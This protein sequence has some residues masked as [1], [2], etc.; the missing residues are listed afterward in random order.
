M[1]LPHALLATALAL[2]PAAAH[3]DTGRS[4]AQPIAV[5]TVLVDQFQ[6]LD[7][8]PGHTWGWQTSAYSRCVDSA[9]KADPWKLDH[10]TS[11]SLSAERGYLTITATREPNGQWS[12][13]LITT[14]DSCDS[15]GDGTQVR[16]G[17]LILVH[18]QLPEADSGAWPGLWT[19]RDGHNEIDVFEWHADRPD[20]LEFVN[21]V[22]SGDTTYT[23]PAIGAGRWIYVGARFGADNT[24]WYAGATLD[25]I[26]A[27]FSDHTGVGNDF[28]AY[29][30]LNL[31]IGNGT[32]HD[33][34]KTDAPVHLSVDLLVIQRPTSPGAPGA[35]A[36]ILRPEAAT[37]HKSASHLLLSPG[38][39]QRTLAPGRSPGR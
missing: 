23:D 34:P 13:G 32:W 37:T 16:T 21:H 22:K 19:W 18:L 3:A 17:D 12:T 20:T 25:T 5:E 6:N 27:A 29:P 31:S 9:D 1:H 8:G 28:A 35:E 30:I 38:P 39:L 24:T 2:T 7:L 14:G 26:K 15:G 4:A 33:P 10:L 11:D 36:P